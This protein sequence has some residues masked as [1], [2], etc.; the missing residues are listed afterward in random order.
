MTNTINPQIEAMYKNILTEAVHLQQLTQRLSFRY[1]DIAFLAFDITA[2]GN[3]DTKE[4]LK[5]MCKVTKHTGGLGR[6][7][8]CG[9][10]AELLTAKYSGLMTY[11]F[12]A[13][14]TK[15]SQ[16]NPF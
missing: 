12:G 6:F 7:D 5:V 16:K 11:L 1:L 4:Y 15:N 9:T 3:I 14:R 8:D 2:D 10:P 13:H